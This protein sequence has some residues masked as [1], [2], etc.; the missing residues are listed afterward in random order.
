MRIGEE[1]KCKKR[2]REMEWSVRKKTWRRKNLLVERSGMEEG[3]GALI[4]GESRGFVDK[5]LIPL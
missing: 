2:E 3:G 1:E 4:S 5:Q